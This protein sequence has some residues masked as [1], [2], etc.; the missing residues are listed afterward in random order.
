MVRGC[1]RGSGGARVHLGGLGLSWLWWFRSGQGRSRRGSRPRDYRGARSGAAGSPE[2]SPDR[3][4]QTAKCARPRPRTTPS[5]LTARSPRR[6]WRPGAN[7]WA[8]SIAAAARPSANRTYHGECAASELRPFIASQS[9]WNLSA[10][11]IVAAIAVKINC[12]RAPPPPAVNRQ[13]CS[14]NSRSVA[15]V[16][17]RAGAAAGI[18]PCRRSDPAA[19]AIY[20]S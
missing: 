19:P 2:R 6:A 1:A 12:F 3:L 18:D 9:N 13:L 8:A 5:A 4:N 11:G 14:G 17:A 20:R 16:D 7:S 10:F 15:I